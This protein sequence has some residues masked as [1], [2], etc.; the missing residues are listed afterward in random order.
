[1]WVGSPWILWS[2]TH[3]RAGAAAIQEIKSGKTHLTLSL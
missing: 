3:D 2:T 1:M